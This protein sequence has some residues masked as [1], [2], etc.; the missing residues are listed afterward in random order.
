MYLFVVRIFPQTNLL[1][2]TMTISAFFEELERGFELYKNKGK[3]FSSDNL[4]VI[5]VNHWTY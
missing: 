4:T 5:L 3:C 2:L 1:L